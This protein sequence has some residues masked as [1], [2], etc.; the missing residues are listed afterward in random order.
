[1]GERNVSFGTEDLEKI[2]LEIDILEENK[3]RI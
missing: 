3:Y 2:D 1:M